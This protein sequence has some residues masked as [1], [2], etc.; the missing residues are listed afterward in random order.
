MNGLAICAGVGGLEL[1]VELA[2]PDY[3]TVCY[4]EREAFAA[5]NLVAQMEH[6]ALAPAPIWS[7]V[8]TFDGSAWRGRVDIV[9]AGF[10]C[11][12]WSAAGKRQGTDDERWIWPDIARTIRDVGPGLVFL[13]N[14][15]GLVAGGGL[16]PV[17]GDLSVL[18]F[19]AEWDVF[20]AAEVGAPHKRERVFIL[21]Y[22]ERWRRDGWAL[23]SWRRSP[24]RDAAGGASE[25]MADSSGRGRGERGQPS[26]RGGQPDGGG[27]AV[28][29]AKYANDEGAGESLGATRG[30][31]EIF[32]PGPAGDWSG[33]LD[34]YPGTEPST[35]GKLNPSFVETL[36]GFPKGWTDVTRPIDPQLLAVWRAVN[37]EALQRATGGQRSL[38]ATPILRPGLFGDGSP[39]GEP[40]TGGMERSGTAKSPAGGVSAVRDSDESSYP[41]QGSELA[42]QRA[43][44]PDDTLLELSHIAASLRRGHRAEA[45]EAAVHVLRSGLLQKRCLQHLSDED[46]EAWN[47]IP[48]GLQ[49]QGIEELALAEANL[50]NRVDRLRACGNGVIPLQ[51]AY[52]FSVLAQRLGLTA[53]QA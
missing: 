21:G 15:P 27:Q 26:G 5:A 24:G 31:C 40:D 23:E 49:A 16:E 12:P 14:V 29:D 4:V 2:V 53:R 1:G 46:Q 38:S 10:P 19:D 22:S 17:L 50:Q 51:A 11:Q 44:Q 43:I 20:S 47:A 36:M 45:R 37:Q 48:E 28:G 39:E 32:P 52:A 30:G 18:G 3:R 42:E 13:E 25:D 7:D 6:G 35:A 41:P 34:A 9:T 8:G 33:W